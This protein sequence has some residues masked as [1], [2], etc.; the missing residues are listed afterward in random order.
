MQKLRQKLDSKPWVIDLRVRSRC[1]EAFPPSTGTFAARLERDVGQFPPADR[2]PLLEQALSNSFR[3]PKCRGV[4]AYA[5]VHHDDGDRGAFVADLGRTVPLNPRRRLSSLCEISNQ[6]AVEVLKTL[7]PAERAETVD[8]FQL[9]RGQADA[10]ELIQL[11]RALAATPSGERLAHARRLRSTLPG[12]Q[13]GP[14]LENV[15]CLEQMKWTAD[16]IEVLQ[17]RRAPGPLLS[18]PALDPQKT[19]EEIRSRIDALEAAGAPHPGQGLFK[20]RNGVTELENARQALT[21]PLRRGDYSRPITQNDRF[22][23][24]EEK[25]IGL[26]ELN[27]LVWEA[28]HGDGELVESLIHALG[29]CIEDDGHRVCG[30]GVTQRLTR[31][32]QGRI[33]GIPGEPPPVPSSLLCAFGE[34]LRRE[35]GEDVD[36]EPDQQ[37]ALAAAIRKRGDELY[38]E[39][40]DLR[41]QL[42][43]S[44]HEFFTY[45][46]GRPPPPGVPAPS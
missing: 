18:P 25:S 23:L 26:A 17:S 33:D 32:L 24:S 21:R 10:Y 36:P 31:F 9:L 35:L 12:H 43:T 13:R 20:L 2:L 37:D 27:A 7:S 34:Q 5:V 28:V 41:E 29:Q 6:N 30:V 46:Y 14:N 15:M 40:P 8:A 42:E 22:K 16:A 39:R 1:R 19:I 11:L 38:A 4:Y 44:L 3:T 45:E